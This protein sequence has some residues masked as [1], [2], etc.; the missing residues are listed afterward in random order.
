MSGFKGSGTLKTSDSASEGSNITING[1][2]VTVALGSNKLQFTQFANS[3]LYTGS[4]SPTVS[5][6]YALSNLGNTDKNNAPVKTIAAETQTYNKKPSD[7]SSNKVTVT[8]VWPVYSNIKS[9]AFTADTT[10][11]CALQSSAVFVF[12][13]TPAEGTYK[14]MFDYPATHTVS[15]FEMKDPSGN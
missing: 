14:F 12:N 4:V 1:E 2:T 3:E 11:R 5:T 9:G 15:K 8:G 13:N 7:V 6:Y 10:T